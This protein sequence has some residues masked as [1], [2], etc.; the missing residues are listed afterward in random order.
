MADPEGL[1]I[2]GARLATT[3]ARD[4]WRRVSPPAERAQLPLAQVRQRLDLFLAALYRGAPAI[5]PSD[6]PPAPVWL[7]RLV[8]RAPRH[9]RRRTAIAST[10]GTRIWLPRTLSAREG[11]A[12]AMQT[13]RLL[14]VEQAARAARD[15]PGH[16]PSGRSD[17]VERDLYI[18]AEAIAVDRS[19]AESFPGLAPDLRAART[20]ALAERPALEKLSLAERA[21]EDIVRR[22]LCADPATPVPGLPVTATPSESL[23]WARAMALRVRRAGG[24][25]RGLAAVS[26]WGQVAG[27]A[28][29]EPRR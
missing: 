18:V 17:P 8:G 22:I 1:L 12:R 24:R 11:E 13:Y 10:D 26:L 14:A 7:A 15:T 21:V 3:A 27:G 19:I 25:Y 20:A 9:L 6:P 28:P 23:A 5:L 2:E 16:A 4:L 29:G